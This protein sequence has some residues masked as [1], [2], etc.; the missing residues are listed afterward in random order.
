MATSG[1]V[2]AITAAALIL[3]ATILVSACGGSGSSTVAGSTTTNAK[4]PPKQKHSHAFM[5]SAD[6][7]AFNAYCKAK[8]SAARRPQVR[9]LHREI[10]A[11]PRAPAHL[12]LR[13]FA[14]TL[15]GLCGTAAGPPEQVSSG[16]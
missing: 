13:K 3:G 4:G 7:A 11:S 1:K 16:G 10:A 14:H 15:R 9:A 6:D 2:A 12:N 8:T 5:I